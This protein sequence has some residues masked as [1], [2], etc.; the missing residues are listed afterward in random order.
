MINFLSTWVLAF[1]L[2]LAAVAPTWA[3]PGV[4]SLTTPVLPANAARTSISSLKASTGTPT[5]YNITSVPQGG[6][7]YVNGTAVTAARAL[8]PTEATQLSFQPS[9]TTGNYSFT[10][11]ATDGS[12]TSAAATYALSVGQGSCGQA[13][14][15]GF[16]TRTANESW[17]SQSA[18]V[19]NVTITTSDYIISAS[20]ADRFQI[21]N[22]Q[23]GNL[24]TALSWYKAYS[25]KNASVS[26]VTFT[27][28]RALT[29]FSIVVQDI[30]ASN[31][32]PATST[33]ID[34]VQ[35]DGYVDNTTT[36]AI[37]LVA[38]NI[39]LGSTNT[40]SGNNRVTGT[41]ASTA[42][43]ADNV[44][45]T[46]PQAI[47]KL[48]LT[49]R[50]TQT[51]TDPPATQ[52][53]GIP[54]FGWCAEADIATTL[55][56]STRAQANST[57]TYTATTTNNGPDVPTTVTPTL[58][59]P[60]GL[61]GVTVSNG[62][63]YNTTSGLVTFAAISNLAV[64]A[65]VTNTVAFTMPASNSVS[66]SATYTSPVL[67]NTTANNTVTL[68]TTQNRAP[69][70]SNVT[71]SPAILSST[72]SQTN[73]AAFNASD[74]DAT[75]GNTTIVSY[76][77]L[78]L[79]TAAQGTLY[80]TV[81]G[82]A[83][84]ATVNQVITVPT[85]ATA[86]NP[87]YQLSFVPNGT[88][89]GNATF[90]YIA[91]DDVGVSSGTAT[92]T[93][94][95]TAGADLLSVVTGQSTGVEGQS[96]SYSVTTT[97]NGPATATNVVPTLTLS[98]KPGFSSVTVTNGSYDPTTGIVTF[99]PTSS[100]ASGASVANTI[101]LAIASS[102]ASFTVTAANTSA[103]ADPTPANNNGTAA[104]AI[105]TV[106]VSPIGPAGTASACA[107]PGRDGSPT[108]TASPNT[109]YPATNQPVAIN[110]TSLSVGAAV[111]ATPIAAGD[112]LLVMQMQGA[113]IDYSNTDSYGDGVAGGLATS[114]LINA[115]FLAGQYEYVVAAGAVPVG[116]GTVT[117]TTGLKYSYQ[118]ADAT[119]TTGQRRFQV[120]RIP[121]Y[122]NLTISGTVAP[123]AWN[124]STGGILALDVTGRLTFA[125]G[126]KLDASRAGF[127]GGAGQKLTGTTGLTGT[128]YRAT[129]P[130]SGTTTTGAH[131]MKG[132][133]IVGTPR[134]VNT[135]TAL[136]DTGVDGYPSGSAGR[137]AP[138]NAG[139]GGTDANPTSN[140]NNSGGG[141]GGNG[142]RG[143]R[144]GNAWASATAVGGEPG[145]GFSAPST[146]RLILG[147]GGG[148]GVNNDG[149]GGGPSAGYASSGAA[150]GGIVL[151][152]TGSVS[153]AGSVL[154][155]GASAGNA[156]LSDGSGGGGAGGSILVTANNTASLASL[157]LTAIG[158]N[159]GTNT[160]SG[161]ATAHGPGG[162]GGG[163]I[164]L[165][166]AAPGSASGA[167]GANGTTTGGVAYGAT[168]G[169]TGIAN[170]QISNSIAGSAAGI[171]C[172]T[173]VVAT[174]SAPSAATVGQTLSLSA[175]F[176]NNGGVAASTVTRT[177]T[178][179]SGDRLNPVNSVTASG[180]TSISSPD[181]TTGAV[182][183]T[184]PGLSSLAAGSSNSFGISYVAPGT[185]SVVATAAITT[186]STEPV[187]DNN[188]SSATTAING[189][190]DVVSAVFGLNSST[191]ARPTATYAVV[192]A[193]NGPAAA[194]NVTRT[195][196]LPASASLTTAQLKTITDQ[197]TPN[198]PTAGYN[199]STGVI[200]FGTVATLDSHAASVF[201]FGY[202]ASNTGGSTNITSTIG[203]TTAQDASNGTGQAADQFAFAVT[204]NAASDLAT[205]GV[206][207]SASTVVPGQPASFTLNFVNYG[208]ADAASALRYAQLTPGL[209][210]VSVTN[211]GVYD[212]TTGI[213]TY[214]SIALANDATAPSTVTFTAPAVG[215]VNISGSLSSG[216]ASSGI[217]N[218]S[219]NQATGSMAVTPV[220]DVAARL[221]GPTSAVAGNLVTFALAATNSGPS[222]AAAV[223]QTVQLPTGLAGVFA[224]GNGTYDATT[225]LVT[226]PALAGLAPGA[227][228]N[229]TV[230]FPMPGAPFAAS[231]S[232]T[233]ATMEATGTTA[234]NSTTL[235]TT[236][237]AAT[238]TDR[239]NVYNTLAYAAQ[240]VAPGA[241][242]TFT[243]VTGNNG[244][245]AALNVVQ[246]LALPPGLSVTSISNGGTYNTTTGVVTFPALASQAS[247]TSVTNT[248]VL[249]APASGPLVA[250]AS[251]ASGTADPVPADNV[252]GLPV[253]IFNRVDVT[254]TLV[255]P[256]VASATQQPT[257]TVTTSNK[258]PRPATNVV[259]TVTIPAGFALANVTTTGGGVYDPATGVITWP[260]VP[261][262]APEEVKTYTYSYL[263]PAL[264]STD[265]NNPRTIVSRATVTSATTDLV[266]A[267]N[268]AAVATA[269]K[270][271]A[272]VSVAVAGPTIA[273]LGNTVTF[274][275]STINNGPAPAANVATSVRIATGL[276]SVVASGGGVY[277]TN[278][279]IVTFPAIANQ[280]AGVTGAVTNTI[281]LV[282]P[283]R[284]I[285][286]VSA[287]ANN[288]ANDTNLTNNAATLVIPVTPRT[289]TQVDLQTTITSNLTSQQADQ[290][291]ILTAKAI[292]AGT[293]ASNM[294]ERV[295]LPAGLSSVVVTDA[296]GSALPGAYDAASG[297]VTFPVASSQAA[298]TTL[299]YT[300]T[301]NDPGN[302][303][304]VATASVNGNFSD[305]TP[306]NNTQ[307]VSVTI[308][309]VADVATRISGP[310]AMLPGGLATYQV[311]T[312]NNGPS[313]ANAVGQTV[314]LPTDLSNVAVSGG[315]SYDAASGLVTFPTIATQAVGSFGEVANTI[316]FTFPTTATS[317][318]GTVTSGT[319]ENGATAN[320]TATLTTT[321]ANQVPLANVTT[322]R[323]QT[324]EG[325]TAAP[326]ALSALTGFDIDG[327]VAS[328]VI[329]TLPATAAG[330]LVLGGTPVGL[331]QVISIADA[332]NL[333]FD[334]AASF[335]GNTFFTYTATDN[336]GAV[337][338]PTPYTIPVGQDNASVYA[339]TPVKGGSNPYQNG[340]ILAN[341]FDDNA[342][343]YNAA[344][345]V[346]D[347][348]VRTAS[349]DG[350]TLPAGT[351]VD[352]VTGQVRVADRTLLVNGTYPVSIITV[353]ANGGVTT[354]SV[355]L[356][357]GTYP[358]PVVLTRFEAEAV[359][360]DSN[361]SWA[362]AQEQSNAGF[363]VERSF[364]GTLFEAL[365]FVPGNGTSTQAHTYSFVDA[366]VGQQHSTVYYR[367]QQRDLDGKTNY[368][369]VRAVAFAP[370]SP[371]LSVTLY[372]NP[373]TEQTTLDLTA[374]PA[375]Q[376]QMRIV[377]LTGRL[378]QTHLLAGGLAHLLAV[379]DLPSGSY[380]V[381]ISNGTLKFSQRLSK[382]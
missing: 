201:Q 342:G 238:T 5:R 359:G 329:K 311:V 122:Q 10:F 253:T 55:T 24:S 43:P 162:G 34:Q 102:P 357:I 112:L 259:Q 205:N 116:G 300:I 147:G 32:T 40:Y 254:T 273:I 98:S 255:G 94:P 137:G 131:A 192:F 346:V 234:N 161:T 368:S 337:S 163:G 317:V 378:V 140:G 213:I 321:L 320:N 23:N 220:A 14:G 286:G 267:N 136:L 244:P 100:L 148:A 8:T 189:Y 83:A 294:R 356:V 215:P 228:V 297:T 197:F 361:L 301:V 157:T 71:N 80:V 336:Q 144:G 67:D 374:L 15:F 352:P 125:T 354:Q 195:V 176:G 156:V 303:P 340:D 323:L 350:S 48:T 348:G 93:V 381:L 86:S 351:E 349:V 165:T 44:I 174:I 133:G 66:G 214:P 155:N 353:D 69:V 355:P 12:G 290:P 206:T 210:G 247:G 114:Y 127:R 16:S 146:S 180:S 38:A 280:A 182:T 90:T 306:S 29:G 119:T 22:D 145:V 130:A 334:P 296:N 19:G 276:T 202:T 154:A 299:T 314:Q 246:Q 315:G 279:G 319:S 287:A 60:T 128:D 52:G 56:G 379:S 59:L 281:T 101:V 295:T 318:V 380:V 85:T 371:A 345:A 199:P 76:T 239:A 235:A 186:T 11:T 262:L 104:A 108:I 68:T 181:P 124:G 88:F 344:A 327:S 200:N 139:G 149:S 343:T 232:V 81:N 61:A 260:A 120:V 251:V 113:D 363:Q 376:Y 87:G 3:A 47:T 293:T 322:N 285:I 248:V 289:S 179:A 91:T 168:A 256:G 249:T 233:T 203:T 240:N 53:I 312:V 126:A 63:T 134:Y 283:D 261:V 77:I 164:V 172:S 158:G 175:V 1:T 341:V 222:A 141:G 45:V 4:V 31:S 325:N 153:G 27:F 208:P 217:F 375:G 268:S 335:V 241:A 51:S 298:G 310:T 193:N 159:G 258:G 250:V 252:V 338:A 96:K 291:I 84:A 269:I 308:V 364:D 95:V 365:A 221:N 123:I 185:A 304:L 326:L 271:N 6:T 41:A 227:F 17:K 224:S 173:D 284:P 358:L 138:G 49:Y 270:W 207:V 150:G 330:T 272:D 92:Y 70:A 328:F 373:A 75:T 118:N 266:T 74:P 257:F 109:Y 377:D 151:V 121:Q 65:I 223:V 366:G 73:I 305:P 212:S 110:A 369:P 9:G 194:A 18:S 178:L 20:T 196:T 143:G 103:T 288:S 30:D 211:D 25:S 13:S 89:A 382:H 333:T 277:D 245:N 142:A 370:Q 62:G 2:T 316:S 191:T 360:L 278:T 105:L 307:T 160:P 230:S 225:G 229:N 372:P 177:V 275:V 99:T 117:F 209:S 309:P 79:P 135:G 169:V 42:T 167:S 107:T 36:T 26:T 243:L 331:N 362:T 263:A 236:T 184:Y 115:N 166:N 302:D 58:Q 242:I 37:P 152:R 183:I 367:L 198:D 190:A 292:N 106:A 111:G 132:E 64:N 218:N 237:P 282:V 78:S 28:S 35:F 264:S 339:T 7:L 226:Y 21:E 97:N 54:S 171:N 57:V 187:T 129:A 231:T 82:T 72:T 46:F 50:N 347:N 216:S 170:S 33:F 219:N 265:A 324:P 204:N 39:K 188:S 332:A 313:P 274:T